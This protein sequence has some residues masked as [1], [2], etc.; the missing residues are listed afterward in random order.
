M[1]HALFADQAALEDDDLVRGAR[2]LGLDADARSSRSWPRG[3]HASR[4]SRD[5]RSGVSS[6]VNGTPT[7]FVNG[8]RHD[9]AWDV[10]TLR[11]ALEAAIAG[12]PVEAIDE[13]PE[14]APVSRRRP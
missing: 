12:R 6:G 13:P 7:F 14:I 10:E 8:L 4:V 5:F 9:E 3:T 2:H 1:H 11:E